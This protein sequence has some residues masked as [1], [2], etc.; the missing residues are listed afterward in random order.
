MDFDD[1]EPQEDD[2]WTSSSDSDDV[3]DGTVIALTPYSRITEHQ[4]TVPFARKR[5]LPGRRPPHDPKR[6]LAIHKLLKEKM[7]LDPSI[8]INII[9]LLAYEESPRGRLT[10]DFPLFQTDLKQI[11][12]ERKLEIVKD[13]A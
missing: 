13:S 9:P 11:Y 3:G 7:Q 4:G 10:L 5:L 1:Q 2:G 12:W 6:E 8:M